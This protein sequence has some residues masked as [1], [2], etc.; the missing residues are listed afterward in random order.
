MLEEDGQAEVICHFCNVAYQVTG[1][2]LEQMVVA[3]TPTDVH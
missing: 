3:K 1:A 2:R